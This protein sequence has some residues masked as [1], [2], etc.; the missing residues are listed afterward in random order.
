MSVALRDFILEAATSQEGRPQPDPLV[1]DGILMEL[2]NIS[3]YFELQ[4]SDH[5]VRFSP[6]DKDSITESLKVGMYVTARDALEDTDLVF[7]EKRDI[8]IVKGKLIIPLGPE[9]AR[10]WNET[11]WSEVSS[12]TAQFRCRYSFYAEP[13]YGD[14]DPETELIHLTVAPLLEIGFKRPWAPD[15]P[16]VIQTAHRPEGPGWPAAIELTITPSKIWKQIRD[17]DAVWEGA[18]RSLMKNITTTA[19]NAMFAAVRKD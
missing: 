17:A 15:R 5:L 7:V 13:H 1:L 14:S 16:P 11:Q 8:V 18:W 19:V 10:T 6:D 2:D 4:Y 9:R 3:D 12:L